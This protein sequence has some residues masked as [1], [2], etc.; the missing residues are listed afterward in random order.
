MA[1]VARAIRP[2]KVRRYAL[3]ETG[4]DEVGN[5]TNG[6]GPPCADVDRVSYR[7]VGLQRTDYR[8][9]DVA[10]VNE[11]SGLETIFEDQRR[12]IVKEPRREDRGD[13]RIWVREGLAWPI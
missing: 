6:H 4:R 5:L 10:D 9:H 2:R 8:L 11:I 7:I 12:M 13:T 1:D 3:A